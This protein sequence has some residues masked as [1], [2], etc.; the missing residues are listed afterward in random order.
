MFAKIVLSLVL[1]VSF[2]SSA[3]AESLGAQ[4]TSRYHDCILSPWTIEEIKNP[5]AKHA[6]CVGQGY[7]VVY[8]ASGVE[9]QL[10][11]APHRWLPIRGKVTVSDYW[12]MVQF[13]LDDEAI[14]FFNTRFASSNARI[15]MGLEIDISPRSSAVFRDPGQVVGLNL[16]SEAGLFL[17]TGVF[18]SYPGYGAVIRNPHTLKA[19]VPYALVFS[20]KGAPWYDPGRYEKLVQG[21]GD[22]RLT[23]QVSLERPAADQLVMAYDRGDHQLNGYPENGSGG[24]F[25]YFVV[26]YDGFHL[27]NIPS[28]RTICWYVKHDD[29]VGCNAGNPFQDSIAES[30]ASSGGAVSQALVANGTAILSKEVVSASMSIPISV[31]TINP[32]AKTNLTG[33]PKV[34]DNTG[35]GYAEGSYILSGVPLTFVGTTDV[36]G[37]DASVGISGKDPEVKV[38]WEVKIG[39]GKWKQAGDDQTINKDRLPKGKQI[40]RIWKYTIPADTPNGTQF[41]I[42]YTVDLKDIIF[43]KYESDNV[44]EE[45]FTVTTVVDPSGASSTTILTPTQ[46]AAVMAIINNYLQDSK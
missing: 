28:Q 36:T 12:I 4:I 40:D 2:V 25:D 23:F 11:N 37:A 7:K 42:R 44:K 33:H 1:L 20:A 22:V 27:M 39:N 35:R 26:A 46:R 3:S 31:G 34:S 38:R 29:D 17:D 8:E 9:T 5:P 19:N 24:G 13:V 43:E 41:S 10:K 32:S 16:P 14:T 21:S 45:T 18:D 15:P 30:V 6:E